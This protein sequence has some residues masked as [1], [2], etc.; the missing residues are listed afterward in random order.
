MSLAACAR[1]K[2]AGGDRRRLLEPPSSPRACEPASDSLP[3]V[4]RTPSWGVALNC[5]V[6]MSA[7]MSMPA[8]MA[9]SGF[10]AGTVMILYSFASTYYVS[11]LSLTHS[12]LPSVP[13]PLT[14]Y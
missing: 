5:I 10:V 6:Y 14:P 13:L 12:L 8:T 3:Q 1:G 2:E 11:E 9:S 7:P 4:R